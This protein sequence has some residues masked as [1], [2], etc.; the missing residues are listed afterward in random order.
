MAEV[1]DT[2]PG[3]RRGRSL[4][5][6][7]DHQVALAVARALRR[8]HDVTVVT[9]GRIALEQTAG[10]DTFDVIFCDVMMPAVSGM[11][12][13]ESLAVSNPEQ[14]QRMV[15]MSGGAFSERSTE[16]LENTANV[17]FAKPFAIESLRS[18]ARDCVR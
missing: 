9:E 13:Y 8:E 12:G 15:F 16:F 11:D 2:G 6:D 5:V 1:R 18:I 17:H 3:I 14:A 10:G 7:D 4:V